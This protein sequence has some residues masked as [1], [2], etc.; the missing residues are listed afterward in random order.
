[1]ILQWNWLRDVTIKVHRLA[2]SRLMKPSDKLSCSSLSYKSDDSWPQD[3]CV[4]WMT[5]D[6]Q[7]RQFTCPP[8]GLINLNLLQSVKKDKQC[9][10]VP[11]FS[12]AQTRLLFKAESRICWMFE[13]VLRAAIIPTLP[14]LALMHNALLRSSHHF[15]S[16][17]PVLNPSE[18]LWASRKT[19]Y[20]PTGS[21]WPVVCPWNKSWSGG[22]NGGSRGYLWRFRGEW[23]RETLTL[24]YLLHASLPSSSFM[25]SYGC[26]WK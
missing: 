12:G 4:R 11:Y 5:S 25:V 9:T 16:I 18:P 13:L 22:N 8:V 3:V 6:R 23:G 24:S 1:M 10:S 7:I 26:V 20:T 2:G 19:C 14:N 15:S 17:W 21:H